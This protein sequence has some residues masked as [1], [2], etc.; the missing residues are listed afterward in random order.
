MPTA[1]IS[2]RKLKEILRIKYGTGLSHRQIG[3][4]LAITPFVLS[5]YANRAAQLGMK[6][7]AEWV[8]AALKYAFLQT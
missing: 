8:D 5:R 7:P 2:M 1:P 3:R 6:W 4:S